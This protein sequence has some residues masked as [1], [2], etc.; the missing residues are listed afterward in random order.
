MGLSG[1]ATPYR[2]FWKHQV[3]VVF[4]G[5][6]LTIAATF[7]SRTYRRVAYP[8]LVL[9]ILG[10]VVVFVPGISHGRIHRWIH[11]GPMNFQPSELA[12]GAIVL[13]L[14]AALAKKAERITDFSMA[15]CR[16]SSLPGP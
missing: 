5:V 9:A 1:L 6:S 2:F 13:Y 12:K 11:L 15:F 8:L 10:V 14:A 7:P 4:G 16:S 3:A